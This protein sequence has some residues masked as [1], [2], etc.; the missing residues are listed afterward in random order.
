MELHIR[1]ASIADAESLAKLGAKTF[2][3][4]FHMHQTE[5]DMRKYLEYTYT[6]EKVKAN[7]ENPAVMYYLATHNEKP[8]GYVKLL[9]GV[10]TDQLTDARV[11]E[12]EK[13]YVLQEYLGKGVGKKLMQQSVVAAVHEKYDWMYLG[14]W[15]HNTRAIEFYKKFGWEVFGVRKFQLGDNIEDD[16]IMRLRLT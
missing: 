2:Y 8:V 6:V 7:L 11:V 12:M 5:E 3:D 14:V 10:V 15:Q 16:Y 9:L 1:Q 4:T 13:I